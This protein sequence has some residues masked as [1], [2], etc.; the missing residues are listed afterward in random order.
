[1]SV[2]A[3]GRQLLRLGLCVNVHVCHRGKSTWQRA[4]SRAI[5]VGLEPRLRGPAR[6][7][8]S[9]RLNMRRFGWLESAAALAGRTEAWLDARRIG[10]TESTLSKQVAFCGGMQTMPFRSSRKTANV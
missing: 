10:K 6:P 5:N 7:E 4:V 9:H 8:T 3:L 2:L 1:M